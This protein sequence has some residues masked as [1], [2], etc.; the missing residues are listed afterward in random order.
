MFISFRLRSRCRG[1]I[2]FI[3]SGAVRSTVGW[4][5]NQSEIILAASQFPGG[6]CPYNSKRGRVIF[7]VP[8][9]APSNPLFPLSDIVQT[10]ALT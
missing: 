8:C 2:C 7:R 5:P 10:V 3:K 1:A 6:E 4:A 9:S